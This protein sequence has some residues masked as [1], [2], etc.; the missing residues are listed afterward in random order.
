MSNL[1]AQI[2]GSALFIGILGFCATAIPKFYREVLFYY[3]YNWDF[4]RESDNQVF[5]QAVFQ[6]QFS[7]LPMGI[8]KLSLLFF[9]ISFFCVL[10]Y[11]YWDAFLKRIL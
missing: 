11:A 3:N 7:F 4:K 6:W 2:L 1:A 8:V 5:L 10:A 9:R